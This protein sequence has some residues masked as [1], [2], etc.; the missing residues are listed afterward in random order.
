MPTPW[1]HYSLS[2]P[3]LSLSPS[4]HWYEYEGMTWLIPTHYILGRA[5]DYSFLLSFF[6]LPILGVWLHTLFNS[7]FFFAC[8]LSIRSQIIE[9]VWERR[10]EEK[11][12]HI[13]ATPVTSL[14][15]PYGLLYLRAFCLPLSLSLPLFPPVQFPTFLSNKSN[16]HPF[17]HRQHT[18]P[19]PLV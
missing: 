4:P 5:L 14:S 10:S 19:S 8:F 6:P 9:R 15:P 16:Q 3:S 13:R 11:R 18:T 2:S 7:L 12:E 1:S 17:Y